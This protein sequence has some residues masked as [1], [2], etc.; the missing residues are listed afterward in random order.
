[1]SDEREIPKEATQAAMILFL[2][3]ARQAVDQAI[4]VLLKQR[5]EI[6]ETLALAE[7]ETETEQ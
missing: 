2:R 7:K 6:Q 5:H 4:S 1:M 3:G